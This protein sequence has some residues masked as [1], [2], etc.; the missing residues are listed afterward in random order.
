MIYVK[1]AM[2]NKCI[3]AKNDAGMGRLSTQT[4]KGVRFFPN[5]EVLLWAATN[6]KEGK[7]PDFTSS[8]LPH[9]G[10]AVFRTGWGDDE[11][12]A[13]FDAS[14]MGANKF[15]Q[16]EDK[17]NLTISNNEKFLLVEGNNYAYDSSD[18]RKYVVSTR[19]HNTV[20]VD[21]LDQV[22][23]ASFDWKH[24]YLT[25]LSDLKFKECADYDIAYGFY[26][27]G[28]G[29]DAVP[30]AKHERTVLF[31]KNPPIGKALVCVLDALTSDET[32]DFE[33]IWHFDV[34]NPKITDF[35]FTSDEISAFIAGDL[36]SLEIVSGIYG[37]EDAQGWTCPSA[38]QGGN[39]PIPTLLHTCR[40]TCCKTVTVFSIHEQGVSAVKSVFFDG[41]KLSIEFTNQETVS[42]TFDKF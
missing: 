29:N 39:I 23:K 1:L 30:L 32:H 4:A 36:G 35:G 7:R 10:F 24:E 41:E 3:P 5:N 2:A 33:S 19:A 17:L 37:D 25:R 20:R 16:H 14:N 27:E 6:G 26:D 22:R 38:L 34:N 12:S 11:V 42:V 31:L 15:H 13:F 9:S 21:R 18:I 40:G 8:Y 28:Y